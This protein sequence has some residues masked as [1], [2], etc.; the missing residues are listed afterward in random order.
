MH[1]LIR[2]DAIVLT[3]PLPYPTWPDP[4]TGRWWDMR[5]PEQ[6]AEAGWV[7]VVIEPRPDNTAT[8]TWERTEPDL[9][10]EKARA[11]VVIDK[12]NNTITGGDTKDVARA[13]KRIADAT[14]D[15]AKFVKNM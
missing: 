11:Q 2:N 1:A 9:Q 15:L 3:G 13:A 10:A 12:P 14:I 8:T 5:D 7:E 4:A 6:V